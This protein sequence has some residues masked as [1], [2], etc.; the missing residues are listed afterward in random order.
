MNT[1][2]T[3]LCKNNFADYRYMYFRKKFAWLKIVRH[4]NMYILEEQSEKPR[5]YT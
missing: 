2:Y 4:P 1:L 5:E 3:L